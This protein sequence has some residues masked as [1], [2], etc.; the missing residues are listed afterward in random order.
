VLAAAGGASSPTLRGS[1]HDGELCEVTGLCPIPV[2]HA[3]SLLTDA[4][5]KL[6][7][8]RGVDVAQVTPFAW[9]FVSAWIT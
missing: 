7:I 9:A 1:V 5:R 8:T 4:T 3:V 6:V 2:A